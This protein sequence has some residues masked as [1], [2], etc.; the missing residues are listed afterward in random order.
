ME[1][2]KNFFIL[3]FSITL[4]FS[5][6]VDVANKAYIQG[7][8]IKAIKY[9]N[10]SYDNNLINS[11]LKLKMCYLK[12]G[13]NFKRI[14]NFDKAMFWYKKA[15]DLKSSVAKYKISI[16]YEKQG[17]QYH[18]IKKYKQ[19]LALYKKSYNLLHNHKV[20]IKIDKTKKILSHLDSAK[21]IEEKKLMIIHLF[22][23]SQLDD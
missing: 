16:I 20:K 19:S 2:V 6:S 23:Q 22:G 21:M 11:K 12:L 17:D 18:K 10:I 8:Y 9:Y 5:N 13:D 4:S 15:L 3:I 7:N 14:S 1:T